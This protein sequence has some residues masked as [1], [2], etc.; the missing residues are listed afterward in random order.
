VAGQ[1]GERD[2]KTKRSEL[3]SKR[4]ELLARLKELKDKEKKNNSGKLMM[5]ILPP[6]PSGIDSF[7]PKDK[8]QRKVFWE[9]ATTT[10]EYGYTYLEEG[11]TKFNEWKDK[12]YED[13]V[14]PI[15][16]FFGWG[17]NEVDRYIQQVWNSDYNING[18]TRTMAEWASFIGEKELKKIVATDRS[19]KFE[20]QKA[21]ENI[22]VKTGDIENIRETLPY[23][24]PEQQDDVLKA[25]TQFFDETHQDR[26]H[27]NGKGMMFTNGTGTGK[28]YTGLGIVKRFVKQGKGRV[29]ILTP[30]QEKVTD[31]R[32]DGRNL[33]L[34]I[35]SLDEEAKNKG[36]SATKSKGKGVV[37]TTYAN[38]RQNLA[39]LEDCFDLIV[40]DESHKIMESKEATNTTMMDF[41]EMLTNKNVEKSMDRQTYWLP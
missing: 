22:A 7:I 10:A 31:W 18:V 34:D 13:F 8:E 3:K 38:A 12:V 15:K 5:A 41:H 23:L 28:T 11:I 21:A 33:G 35:E 24:L 30:S 27:G 4:D 29:L 40:Y 9:L 6:A 39:M 19:T 25:E 14:E 26:E 37:V 20:Q 36:T 17:Q 32:N 2:I 16:D 1:T